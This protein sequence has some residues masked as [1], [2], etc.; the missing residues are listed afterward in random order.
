M[1]VA[2]ERPGEGFVEILVEKLLAGQAGPPTRLAT[3]EQGV[4]ALL[5]APEVFG[6]LDLEPGFGGVAYVGIGEGKGGLG[7]RYGEEW[8]PKNSGRSSPRRTLGSLLVSELNLQ[9]RP[10][11]GREHPRNAQYYVFAGD[12]EQILTDWLDRYAKFSY[13]EVPPTALDEE[14]SL[15]DV[16]TALIQRLKPPLNLTKWDNPAAS[17]LGRARKNAAQIAKF[18]SE[19][20]SVV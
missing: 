3:V 18:T 11:P 10:R 9:P 13:V 2:I 8:R 6:A 17:R 14:Y 12:G 5:L 7:R 15:S 4:Y 20:D 16:E 19:S 1:T